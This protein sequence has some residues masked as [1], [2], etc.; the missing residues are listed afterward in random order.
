MLSYGL[1][2]LLAIAGIGWRMYRKR[3][4]RN[5]ILIAAAI[6]CVVGIAGGVALS[7]FWFTQVDYSVGVDAAGADAGADAG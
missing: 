3:A 4:Y 1:P 2:S 7:R 5:R 6:L